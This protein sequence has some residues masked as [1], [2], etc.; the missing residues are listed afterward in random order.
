MN[1]VG[2]VGHIQWRG[3]PD[4]IGDRTME[5]NTPRL[6]DSIEEAF[7][8]LALTVEV[9]GHLLPAPEARRALLASSSREVRDRALTAVIARARESE[10]GKLLLTGLLLPALRRLSGRLARQWGADPDDVDA[11]VCL[12]LT[13]VA[14]ERKPPVTA[15]ASSVV[16]EVHRRVRSTLAKWC[17]ERGRQR[18]LEEVVG[19]LASPILRLSA[20]RDP[21]DLVDSA[22]R[23][24][25]LTAA[26]ATLIVTTRLEGR[27]LVAV[28]RGQRQPA[29]RLFDRL[30]GAAAR[31]AAVRGG[32]G[33]GACRGPVGSGSGRRG[34]SIGA[35]GLRRGW[36]RCS[37]G[38]RSAGAGRRCF[39]RA[40]PGLPDR[41]RQARRWSGRHPA[42]VRQPRQRRDHHGLGPGHGDRPEGRV[43]PRPDAREPAPGGSGGR[44]RRGAGRGR[45]RRHWRGA[46][47]P[48][49]DLAGGELLQRVPELR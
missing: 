24:G 26:E 25:V 17:G 14:V 28:A 18:C 46:A 37:P 4:R 34:S 45:E 43:P 13:E 21:E 2:T 33:G 10:D 9:G 27:Q 1:G 8:V 6:L 40:L 44:G 5:R 38:M 29:P 11:E 15:V 31:L 23:Q 3:H 39:G 35:A 22:V 12:A 20:P 47:H 30:P 16:W 42:R 19:V 41:G 36:S 49:D 7:G 32:P 48:G